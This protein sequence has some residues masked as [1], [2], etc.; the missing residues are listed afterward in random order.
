MEA[1]YTRR[2]A[3]RLASLGA[4]IAPSA[5]AGDG[6]TQPAAWIAKQLKRLFGSAQE[7]QPSTTPEEVEEIPKLFVNPRWASALPQYSGTV[8]NSVMTTE[9]VQAALHEVEKW[10]GYEPTP[11]VSLP[12]LATQFDVGQL[13]CKHEGYRFEPVGSFKPTGVVYALAKLLLAEV[14]RRRSS[15]T[16]P[17]TPAQSSSAADVLLS[18]AHAELLKDV[19]VCAAT[20]GN[21]GRALAWGAQLFGCRCVIYMGETVSMSR[22]EAIE[23]F[24]ATV[25]RVNGSYDDVVARSEADA[26]SNGYFVISNV[27]YPD[28][29]VP[30]LIMHGYAIT[31]A[32][33]ASQLCTS[34]GAPKPP[35]THVFICGGGGRFGAGVTAAL[36]QHYGAKRPRCILVEPLSSAALQASGIAGAPTAVSPGASVMDGLVVESASKIGYPVLHEAA[37]AFLAVPDSAAVAAM[38][39][40]AASGLVVGET[41]IAGW[42][43]FC[44]AAKDPTIRA[45]LGLDSTSRVCVVATEGATD[46]SVYEQIVGMTPEAVLAG[47]A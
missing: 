30:R 18:G 31:G 27:A 19:T 15:S 10:K 47:P 2:Y 42:A 38:R 44:V 21:H 25:I 5:S 22:Q 17:G 33:I 14:T 24:G 29:D 3:R 35:P 23:G 32:E 4:H 16:S 7:E 36:W 12:A 41:G 26:E 20:S 1:Q 43:G 34:D 28:V 45:T 40:L 37:F 11:L 9:D 39:L 6:G 13:A 46:P 8:H